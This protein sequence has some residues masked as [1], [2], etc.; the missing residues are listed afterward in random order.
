MYTHAAL[1]PGIF[2]ASIREPPILELVVLQGIVCVLSLIWHRN[3]EHEDAFAKI[4]HFFA[5]GL[6]A[7]GLSQ[8]LFSPGLLP[9]LMN[10]TCAFVTSTV[11]VV[12]YDNR[13]LW[14]RWH[15]IG[16]HVVPGLW[17]VVI[18]SMHERFLF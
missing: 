4:E 2:I 1:L 11:Y 14:E 16:L 13:A 8:T 5:H 17:S 7:Y 12:T 9:L 18:A 6:F 3:H 15:A 10:I